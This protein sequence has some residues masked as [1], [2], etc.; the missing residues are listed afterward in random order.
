MSTEQEDPDAP[1][2]RRPLLL[3]AVLVVAV[4][5]FGLGAMQG[6]ALMRHEPPKTEVPEPVLRAQGQLL[7]PTS[8]EAVLRGYGTARPRRIV[9]IAPEVG[10]EV[11][12]VHPR[13]DTGEIIAEG[14]LLF[15]ID[16]EDY[17]I[18]VAEAEA[19][20][21]RAEA[22]LVQ[23]EREEA[24]TERRLEVAREAVELARREKNRVEELVNRGGVESGARLD[25]A[26]L[27]LNREELALVG[28]ENT[29]ALIPAQR[30]QLQAQL[31]ASRSRLDRAQR[32]LARA[33]VRAPFTGRLG[34]VM[35]EAGQIV[36]AQQP[37]LQMADDSILE[38]PVDLDSREVAR[39][40]EFDE[41]PLDANWFGEPRARDVKVSWTEN[42]E[43]QPYEGNL[44]RVEAYD[45]DTRT[46]TLIV[47]VDGRGKA[48]TFPLAEG[49]F[50]QVAITGKTL[51][52]VFAIPR[53]AIDS[54]QQVLV[55]RDVETT[56]GEIEG[57]IHT[58]AVEIA[59]YQGGLAYVA[60]GLEAG[61]VVLVTRPPKVLDGTLVSVTLAGSPAPQGS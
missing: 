41:S 43:G 60:Q 20:V 34:E 15:Q 61:D 12:A 14:E 3:R 37:A 22:D 36:T 13:L 26:R 44:A 52:E 21:A 29:L 4:L 53:E 58:Q 10:G 56:E 57:R 32:N 55:L 18:A 2:P 35:V 40:L 46:F 9:S 50:T 19:D 28:L 42:V 8:L 59:R 24:N 31:R 7:E 17:R 1:E 30:Q 49:M 38:I 27:A 25:A 51:P 5:L 39:W 23:I 6:L 48:H 47:E 54:R 33:D 11:I 16:P 45:P